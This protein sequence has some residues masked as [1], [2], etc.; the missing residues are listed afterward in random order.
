MSNGNKSS[1]FLC[2]GKTE[3]F[4]DGLPGTPDNLNFSPDGN[5]LVS[6]VSVRLPGQFNPTEM[7]Y[8]HPWLRKLLLRTLHLVKMPLDLA[9]TYL[10]FPI[11]RKLSSYVN[12]E[13]HV[14][15]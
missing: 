12:T 9:N 11:T 1:L 5:I 6:L 10:E 4:I 13:N 7:M 2:S 15:Y 8:N 3:V 14:F